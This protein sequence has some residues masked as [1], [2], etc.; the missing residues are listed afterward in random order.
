VQDPGLERHALPENDL[1]RSR[2]VVFGNV[3]L[4]VTVRKKVSLDIE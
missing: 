3:D 4:G 2:F 1:D